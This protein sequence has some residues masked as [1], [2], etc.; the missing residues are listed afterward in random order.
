VEA[1]LCKPGPPLSDGRQDHGKFRG[2]LRVGQTGGAFQNDAGP[3]RH[4]LGGFA[5]AGKLLQ[6]G[7][8]LSGEFNDGDRA[9]GGHGFNLTP[10][11][12]LQAK[13]MQET[14]SPYRSFNFI[15]PKDLDLWPQFWKIYEKSINVLKGYV[16]TDVL[17]TVEFVKMHKINLEILSRAG[18]IFDLAEIN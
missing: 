7:A 16:D 9:A 13:G 11:P 14:D 15:V 10:F 4:G 12:A 8:F 3:Q 2:H 5:A 18:E 1:A 6:L 17:D